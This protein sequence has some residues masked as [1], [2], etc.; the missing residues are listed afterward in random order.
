MAIL[1]ADYSNIDHQDMA[2]KI[3]LNIKHIPI[4]IASFIEETQPAIEQ[5]STAIQENDYDVIHRQAHFIKGSAGNLQFNEV[6]EM[7][8]EMELSAT[9][10]KS[11]FD[12]LGYFNAIKEALST[13]SI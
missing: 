7:S 6:Y 4:L 9:D 13:I 2:T 8:K 5:L 10:K 11:D 3:G 1:Q 12:Y